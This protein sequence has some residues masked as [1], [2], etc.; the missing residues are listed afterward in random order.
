[1]SIPLVQALEQM[2][3]EP[4]KTYRYPVKGLVVEVRLLGKLPSDVQPVSIDE[5]DL[6]PEAAWVELPG[7]EPTFRV[8]VAPG[9]LP[10]PHLPEM[11]PADEDE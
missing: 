5:S 9:E 10:P 2:N 3:L 7:P 11:P 6:A 4:G 8:T 1:M